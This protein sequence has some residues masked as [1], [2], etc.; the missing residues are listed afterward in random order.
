MARSVA[1]LGS[2]NVGGNRL[3]MADLKVALEDAGLA[4]VGTVVA[5]GNVLFDPQG[6]SAAQAEALIAEILADKFG[7]DVLVT[8][9]SR[10][11][12]GAAIA[13]NPFHGEGEDKFVHTHFLERQPT[14]AQFDKLVADHA[15]RGSE[16]LA[17]GERMLFLDY[18]NGVADSKLTGAFM[19]RR[20][21]SRGTARNMRSLKRI[22]EKM[23]A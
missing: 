17:L 6:R 2:I 7:L 16:R 23:E 10:D 15:G 9:R 18:G 12:V 3:K 4:Q 11:E 19:E 21:E 5:S 8:V 22:L 14:Q 1:F 20:L 13:N